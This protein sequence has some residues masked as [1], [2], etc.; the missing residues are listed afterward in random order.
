[1]KLLTVDMLHD[2]GN[3]ILGCQVKCESHSVVSDSLWTHGL[4]GPWNSLGQNT[5]V[6][7]LS[8]LQGIFPTQGLNPGLL[9]SK[10]I[11]YQLSHQGCLIPIIPI[12]SVSFPSSSTLMTYPITEL[13]DTWRGQ[14]SFWP[15]SVREKRYIYTTPCSFVFSEM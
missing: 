15:A 6:G 9:H 2:N 5:G 8:L 13:W 1:M 11:H 7:S 3:G 14:P 12:K 4:Y 10:W